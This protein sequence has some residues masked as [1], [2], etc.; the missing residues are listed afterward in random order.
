MAFIAGTKV[1]T[2]SGWKNIEDVGGRDRVL[3]RNFLGDAQFTQPFAVKKSDYSGKLISGGST[4]YQFKVTPEHTIVYTDK[5]GKIRKTTAEKVPTRRENSLKHRSRYSTDTYL[6]PQKIKVGDFE[7]TVDTLDW[8]RLVGF[9]LRRGRVDKNR[10]RLFLALDKKN[11]KKDIDL[12][13]PVLDR[14]GLEWTFTK[15]NLVVVSQKSN[16]A[17]KLAVMLGT[18]TRKDMYVPDKMIYNSTLEQARALIETF[19][20][21]SRKDGTWNGE[22]VQ[23]STSNTKL[24]DSLE[25]LGLLSGYTISRLLH[26]PAG[27]KVPRGVTKRDT[28]VVYIRKSVNEISIIRKKE[29]DYNGKVFEIDMFED[30]LLI[31]EDQCLPVWMKPK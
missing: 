7:Y 2:N 24:I 11:V 15:P 28:Y 14:M 20:L 10:T 29:H 12:I 31:R 30:Q 13:C 6:R 16:I 1:L 21:T 8:Y 22:N 23:F 19:V 4:N 25:I 18:K 17:N 26:R 5:N 3:V 9:V 27:A